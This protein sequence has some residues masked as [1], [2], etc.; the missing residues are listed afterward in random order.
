MPN[1]LLL[2]CSDSTY[3]CIKYMYLKYYFQIIFHFFE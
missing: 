2:Y 3:N 1:Y